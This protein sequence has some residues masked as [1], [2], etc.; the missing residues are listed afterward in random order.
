[1]NP[2]SDECVVKVREITKTFQEVYIA[3]NMEEL[4]KVHLMP[5]PILVHDDGTVESEPGWE[6]FPDTAGLVCGKRSG[7]FPGYLTT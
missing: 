6:M 2:S 1:M 3:A 4:N 5:Y 7:V